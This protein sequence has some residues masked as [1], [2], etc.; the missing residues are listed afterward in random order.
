[1]LGQEP[2]D[3]PVD[4]PPVLGQLVGEAI[5]LDDG[6]L[7]ERLRQRLERRRPG[8]HR[9]DEPRRRTVDRAL[10][11]PGQETGADH[12]GLAGARATDHEHEAAARVGARQPA[13]DLLHQV[14][15]AEVVRRVGLVEGPQA[16][17][18]VRRGP[19]GRRR[20]P[21]A[22]RSAGPR[23][24]PPTGGRRQWPLARGPRPPHR[25]RRADRPGPGRRGPPRRPEPF[26]PGSGTTG[27]KSATH[28]SPASSN[29]TLSADN[30]PWLMPTSAAATSAPPTRSTSVATS[31]SVIG[32]RPSRSVNV[33]PCSRRMTR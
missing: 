18:G 22:L 23:T 24:R 9:G 11:E 19:L 5:G 6:H 25:G 31:A 13:E 14:G 32:R 30:R 2:A 20:T 12:A 15:P 8:E 28:A 27:E 10:A 4:A 16:L 7:A 3:D 33:P 26:S 21:S 17:V 1:M 29:R